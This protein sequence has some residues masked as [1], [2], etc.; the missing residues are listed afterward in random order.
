MPI[1]RK[2][3]AKA[4]QENTTIANPNK[5]TA[6]ARPRPNPEPENTAQ[7][8]EM[9]DQEYTVGY[10]KPPKSTQFKKGQSGNPNG[11]PKGAKGLNSIVKQHLLERVAVRTGKGTKRIT[12]IEALVLKLLEAAGNGEHRALVQLM[13]MYADA[14]PEVTTEQS[15]LGESSRMTE[16]DEAILAQFLAE[17]A[18]HDKTTK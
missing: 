10:G 1:R 2:R 14:V 7:P 9:K 13:S 18:K 6:R 16:T 12:R 15:A 17:Q 3:P 4:A 8:Q 11:R 5:R